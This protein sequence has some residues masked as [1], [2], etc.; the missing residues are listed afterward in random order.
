MHGELLD[1]M[2]QRFSFDGDTCL[3][4]FAISGARYVLTVQAFHNMCQW[5]PFTSALATCGA[6]EHA[7]SHHESTGSWL[8]ESDGRWLAALRESRGRG[9]HSRRA[10]PGGGGATG[11]VPVHSSR[12]GGMTS[13]MTA[14]VRADRDK[15]QRGSGEG[16]RRGWLGRGTRAATHPRCRWRM[17]TSP[18]VPSAQ[19][20]RARGER[21]L[22]ETERRQCATS[23][24]HET[25]ERALCGRHG[26]RN[27]DGVRGGLAELSEDRFKSSVWGKRKLGGPGGGR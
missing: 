11:V 1:S 7:E 17:T 10:C 25:I 20:G 27:Y 23:H 3:S 6:R 5:C 18:Q 21:E 8:H 2:I 24:L 4:P 9:E 16:Q 13:G 14:P 26:S 19:G 22:C 15:A 12:S